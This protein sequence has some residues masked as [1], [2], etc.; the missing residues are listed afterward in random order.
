MTLILLKTCVSLVLLALGKLLT[1]GVNS[2]EGYEDEGGFHAVRIPVR[3][4]D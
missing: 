2:P 4:H 1:L 3:T